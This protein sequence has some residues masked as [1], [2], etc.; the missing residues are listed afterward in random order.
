MSYEDIQQIRLPNRRFGHQQS[1]GGCKL[2]SVFHSK[3]SELLGLLLRLKQGIPEHYDIL[4]CNS[5]TT[6]ND[7]NLFLKRAQHKMHRQCFLLEINKLS[8]D[9]QEV[10]ACVITECTYC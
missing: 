7:M 2:H 4:R 6:L 1:T 8:Y 9:V 5:K 10:M 3:H